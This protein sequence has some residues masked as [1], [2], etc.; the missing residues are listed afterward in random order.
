MAK[1]TKTSPKIK[2]QKTIF[3]V[4][5]KAKLSFYDLLFSAAQKMNEYPH[6]ITDKLT[7]T[8]KDFE[9]RCSLAIGH[10]N[11]AYDQ[12]SGNIEIENQN[13]KKALDILPQALNV[14]YFER[15][16]FRRQYLITTI[17]N[18][19]ELKDIIDVKLLSQEDKFREILSNQLDDFS[20]ALDFSDANSKIHVLIGPIKKLEIPKYV[21]FNRENHLDPSIREESYLKILEAYPDVAIFIDIDNYR[22]EEEIPVKEALSF[23]EGAKKKI[24]YIVTGF[25]DYLLLNK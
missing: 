15:L 21:H 2:L 12:D 1:K 19:N 4:R 13:I 6:W 3:E 20:F 22:E 9:K 16:G 8:L 17:L 5:Y 10:K 7:I 25:N 18:F 14:S 24:E 23:Y 11:I